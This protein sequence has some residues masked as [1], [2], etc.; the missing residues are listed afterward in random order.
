MHHV[1][2]RNSQEFQKISKGKLLTKT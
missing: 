2:E 1:R